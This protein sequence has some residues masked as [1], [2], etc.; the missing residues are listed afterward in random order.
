VKYVW[1]KLDSFIASFGTSLEKLAQV[2]HT[3]VPYGLVFTAF[4]VGGKHGLFWLGWIV[5][6]AIAAFAS[7]K[8]YFRDPLPPENAP[9]RW[10]GVRDLSFYMLGIAVAVIAYYAGVR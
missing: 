2:G 1:Q 10:N 5:A 9:W 6:A 8:E 3:A 7:W 4:V